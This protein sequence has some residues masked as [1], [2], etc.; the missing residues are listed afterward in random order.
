MLRPGIGHACPLMGVSFRSTIHQSSGDRKISQGHVNLSSGD[1]KAARYTGPLYKA[2]TYTTTSFHFVLTSTCNYTIG[3]ASAL[4][5]SG[6]QRTRRVLARSK[7]GHYSMLRVLATYCPLTR[8][9]LRVQMDCKRRWRRSFA[10]RLSTYRHA[11]Y[12]E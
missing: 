12:F 11:D 2:I 4:S 1:R 10:T 9:S 3:H 6:Q 7:N 8:L 5:K